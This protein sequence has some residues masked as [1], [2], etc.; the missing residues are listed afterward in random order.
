MTNYLVNRTL[1]FLLF[2]Q[3]GAAVTL[4]FD[5][6]LAAS[7]QFFAVFLVITLDQIFGSVIALKKDSFETRK[8]FKS[9][10]K[11]VAYW[12]ILAVV[13]AIESGYSYMDWLSEAVMLPLIMF[14]LISVLK[15]MQILG[16]IQD[17]VLMQILSKIDKYKDD[18]K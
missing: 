10:Y 2:S 1:V 17:N 6:Y 7:M 3:I 12:S 9:V 14:T 15:N 13:I 4:L 5:A 8:A 18:P 16:L 11:M